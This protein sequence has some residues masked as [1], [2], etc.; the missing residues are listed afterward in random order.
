MAIHQNDTVPYY[1]TD[2]NRIDLHFD[3]I[4]RQKLDDTIKSIRQKTPG[5]TEITKLQLANLPPNMTD[6][7]HI[8]CHSDNRAFS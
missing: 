3:Y 1:Q 2:Y 8:K 5:Q 7:T 6:T 4:T